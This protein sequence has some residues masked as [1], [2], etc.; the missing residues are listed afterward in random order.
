[1]F[2][3]ERY[4]TRAEY[5]FDRLQHTGADVAVHDADGA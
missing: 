2:F 5:F 1:M 3:G 4:V